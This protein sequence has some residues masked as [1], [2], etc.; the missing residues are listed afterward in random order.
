[1]APVRETVKLM[2]GA[3]SRNMNYNYERVY[4]ASLREAPW[5]LTLGT[6]HAL[7]LNT[8]H[9]ETKIGPQA[10]AGQVFYISGKNL[11]PDLHGQMGL[12]GRLQAPAGQA[13]IFSRKKF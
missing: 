12:A 2:V 5:F 1:M 9:W 6:G 13:S 4:W 7:A 11:S 3:R 8:H 10:P